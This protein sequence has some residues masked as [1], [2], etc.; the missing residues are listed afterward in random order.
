MPGNSLISRNVTINGRR[1]SIR[2]ELEN[3]RALEEICLREGMDIHQL[4][5][6]VEEHR[7]ISN[8][9]SAIR[10]FIVSYF[11]AAATDVGHDLAGHGIGA[12]VPFGH[13]SGIAASSG[14]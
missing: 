6:L 3:W 13:D 10:A 4:C 7:H 12:I 1:T 9:T 14:E 11:R 5:A 8:R 2:L